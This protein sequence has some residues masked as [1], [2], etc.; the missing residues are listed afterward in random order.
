[1]HR[2]RWCHEEHNEQHRLQQ[3]EGDYEPQSHSNTHADTEQTARR[4]EQVDVI[5]LQCQRHAIDGM[6]SR[7]KSACDRC[8]RVEEAQT[9]QHLKYDHLCHEQRDKAD[10]KLESG[11]EQGIEH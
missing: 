3:N 2:A 5:E 11:S 1:M 4:R 8:Q 6:S 7:K 9:K 10:K